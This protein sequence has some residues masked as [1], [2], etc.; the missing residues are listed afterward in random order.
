MDRVYDNGTS[1]TVTMFVGTEVEH[2]PAHGM[3]TLFVVGVHSPD[4]IVELVKQE[5]CEHV[6]LGANMSYE[7]TEQ[8]DEMVLPLL[9]QGLLVTLDFDVKHCEW[10]L[11][12]GYT[13]YHNFI[14][15]I[16]VKL[17]YINQLGYNAC[18]KLDDKDF[19]ASNPGVWV[20]S[21]HKLQDRLVFTDWS[22]YTQD[23][24]LETIGE[25]NG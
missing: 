24:P 13:E 21:V 10:I 7:P 20:H 2:T 12:S 9:K 22:K 15:M 5:S 4:R 16:S 23:K 25:T 14:S 8:W 17:P 6:Y 1:N 3:R 18:I 19:D 11:E